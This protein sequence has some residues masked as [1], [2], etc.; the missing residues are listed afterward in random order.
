MKRRTLV[1]FL[2]L[3][4]TLTG[5]TIGVSMSLK[6]REA[7]RDSLKAPTQEAPTS[8]HTLAFGSQNAWANKY[9]LSVRLEKTQFTPRD[10]ILLNISLRN[11][12]PEALSIVESSAIRDYKITVR[13]EDGEDLQLSEQGKR[14][15][16]ASE[17]Y[18]QLVVQINPGEEIHQSI[19]LS[20]LYD[21]TPGTYTVRVKRLILTKDK[22]AYVELTSNSIK[23]EV[24]SEVTNSNTGE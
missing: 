9:K 22:T 12:S 8:E 11:K 4:V 21:L 14:L 16:E 23:V 17:E 15:L 2:F 13:S 5:L 19:E 6:S 1:V 7:E 18:R 20:K 24:V 10:V 3:L